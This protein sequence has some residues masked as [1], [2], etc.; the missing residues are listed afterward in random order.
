MLVTQQHVSSTT[1]MGASLVGSGATFRVWAPGAESVHVVGRFGGADDWEHDPANRLHRD[2]AGYWAGFV[3]GVRD[4]DHYKLYVV[5]LGSSGYKRDPYA[6]ELSTEPA[7]PHCNCIVRDPGAY[8]WHDAGWRPPAFNDLIVYQF[9]IGTFAAENPVQQVGTLLD[10]L[11]RLEH[12]VALGVN[13]IEPLPVVEFSSP[14]SQGYDGSDLFSPEM[15]YTL[16]GDEV[17]P[18]LGRVN[19]LLVRHG[20]P[21]LTKE[22]LAVPINQLKLLVDLC[23]LNGIA[24]LLDV[25]YNHAGYQIGGQ[26]ES[27]WFFDRAPG[28]DPNDS[29][30]FTD[31]SHVGPVFAFWKREVRQFLI[32]NAGF[33]VDEYHIDGLRYDQ[34]SVIVAENGSSG[35]EFSQNCTSTVRK[36]QPTVANVAEYWPVDPWVPK[37]ASEGGAGFDCAWT[38]GIRTAVRDAVAAASRGRDQHVDMSRIADALWM[39]GFG[40]KWRGVQYVESHDE[41]LQKRGERLP[42]L[43]DSSNARSWYARSR[44]RFATGLVLTAPGIPMLF[45]G[46]EFLEDKQWS[47]DPEHHPG[48]TLYW[49]GLSGGNP[50][51]VDHLRF[52]RELIA[53]RRRHPALRGE[54]LHIIV[55]DD[56]HRVLAFQRWVEGEGYDIVV[57]V[58]LNEAP[59]FGYRIGLPHQGGWREVFNSDVYE[60][61]PNPSP[62]GNFGY[63]VAGPDGWN[64]L[65]ASVA[66]NIPANG[67]LVLAA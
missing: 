50:A 57:I 52:V 4:G 34:V 29:L 14:R 7:Y 18:H 27:I 49:A 6:R 23:H 3:D 45:M 10:V 1:P 66:L 22:Q 60:S 37:P 51:M 64:G 53:L 47:D 67:L 19:E 32:D 16:Q 31:R 24:V 35:W 26:D 20:Q 54:G 28:H 48:S 65:A 11:D 21:P 38:D 59:L 44:S 30:Y 2:E 12:L 55:A 42:R 36:F 63:V 5:G 15:D 39:H 33:F 40:P 13:A 58:S 46:Q 43:S 8:P 41:V 56:Y 25:V 9:H 61:W 17:D 62:I